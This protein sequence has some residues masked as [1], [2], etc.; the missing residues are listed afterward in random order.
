MPLLKRWYFFVLRVW[1]NRV[2]RGPLVPGR[3]RTLHSPAISPCIPRSM[4]SVCRRV[5]GSLQVLH[6]WCTPRPLHL[7][8]M[9]SFLVRGVWMVRH[10][11]M[12]LSSLHSGE[13]YWA[14][15]LLCSAC[16]AA[17][18]LY[19]VLMVSTFRS[20]GMG[21]HPA[22][23]SSGHELGW[24]SHI[25]VGFSYEAFSRCSLSRAASSARRKVTG[26]S[27]AMDSIAAMANFR[28][29]AHLTESFW[30]F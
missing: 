14:M 5:N 4:H 9:A 16:S 24:L 11:S 18:D 28:P 3:A 29:R 20:S 23:L 1:S 13:M 8:A 22:A 17:W 7:H 2:Y 25:F 27:P 19:R 30:S 15:T 10:A 6:V 12:P 26:V 21:K